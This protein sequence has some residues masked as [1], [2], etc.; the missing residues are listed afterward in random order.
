MPSS[1]RNFGDWGEDLARKFLEKNDFEILKNNFQKRFGEIDIIAEKKG[2]LHFI[3]V[4]TR[5][6]SSVKKFGLPEE[7]VTEKKQQKIIA[8]A[9]TYLAEN[10]YPSDT[11]WQIDIISIITD[12]SGNW[13]KINHI[14]N[15]FDEN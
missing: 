14:L 6:E 3:E 8:T 4:K 7:A 9:E 10:D 11:D 2:S 15:A 13:A 1:K 5:T 12:N